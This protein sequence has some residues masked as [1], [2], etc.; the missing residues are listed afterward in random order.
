MPKQPGWFSRRYKTSEG[1]VKSR[2]AKELR[3]EDWLAT[4]EEHEAARAKRSVAEQLAV[5][6]QRLGKNKGAKKER[7]RLKSHLSRSK[8]NK[9]G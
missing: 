1:L 4:M 5:L 9:S 7:A 6:D 2:L 8:K 3:V